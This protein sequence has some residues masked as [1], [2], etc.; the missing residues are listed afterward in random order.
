MDVVFISDDVQSPII[1][2]KGVG[3]PD[4]NIEQSNSYKILLTVSFIVHLLSNDSNVI[5]C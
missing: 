2:I 4:P 1:T 3:I 5:Q